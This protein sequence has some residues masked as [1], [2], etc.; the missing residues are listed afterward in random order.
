MQK[1]KSQT[2]EKFLLEAASREILGKGVKKLRRT[3]MI[4]ANIYGPN[5]KSASISVS[6]PDFTSTYKKAHE[7]GIVYLKVNGQEIPTLVKNVQRHPVGSHILHIDFRKIDLTQKVET[8]VP[9]V[10]VGQSAAVTQKG[11]V[12]LTQSDHLK[13]EAL[14]ADI[15][16]QIEVDISVLA[17]IDQSIKVSDLPRST[18][19]EIKEDP[20]KIVVSVIAHKEE[21]L[22]PET[23]PAETPEVITEKPEE[24]AEGAEA[25]AAEAKGGKEAA[26]AQEGEKPEEK[27][28]G[29]KAEKTPEKLK[30]ESKKE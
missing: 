19:Y 1:T 24:G 30:E 4:P 15:P 22:E 29:A 28:A 2:K 6:Y 26:P 17:E 18:T 9:V 25:P 12:L 3:G 21:S 5:F 7:T 10:V 16:Q 13:V 14:P 20:E 11:G 8:A 23:A 27:K